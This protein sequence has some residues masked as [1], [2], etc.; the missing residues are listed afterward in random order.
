MASVQNLFAPSDLT[1]EPAEQK[2]NHSVPPAPPLILTKGKSAEVPKKVRSDATKLAI[3]TMSKIEEKMSNSVD[4]RIEKRKQV[5]QDFATARQEFFLSKEYSQVEGKPIVDAIDAY[6]GTAS[7]HRNGLDALEKV[8]AIIHECDHVDIDSYDMQ[9]TLRHVKKCAKAEL[10]MLQKLHKAI[11]ALATNNSRFEETGIWNS[12]GGIRIK[13]VRLMPKQKGT[14]FD[15]DCKSTK[16]MEDSK[17][18]ICKFLEILRS[19]V[20]ESDVFAELLIECMSEK[21]GSFD[22]FFGKGS[23]AFYD[24]F[25]NRGVDQDDLDWLPTEPV[26][27]GMLRVGVTQKE[28][29]AHVLEE[30]LLSRSYGYK[31][32]M[33]HSLCLTPGSYQNRYRQEIGIADP[34]IVFTECAHETSCGGCSDFQGIS[35]LGFVTTLPNLPVNLK[36]A[37]PLK[38]VKQVFKNLEH[39]LQVRRLSPQATVTQKFVGHDDHV[40]VQVL[41]ELISESLTAIK[42]EI[43]DPSSLVGKAQFEW[44]DYPDLLKFILMLNKDKSVAF[45]RA[46]CIK[47]DMNAYREA[48]K[49]KVVLPIKLEIKKAEAEKWQRVAVQSASEQFL[50]RQR[51]ERQKQVINTGTQGDEW[52]NCALCTLGAIFNLSTSEVS[53]LVQQ[54]LAPAGI[55]SDA[56]AQ[57]EYIFLNS[58]LGIGASGERK[59]SQLCPVYVQDLQKRTK[60]SEDLETNL[61]RAVEGDFQFEGIRLLLE[62]GV[63]MRNRQHGDVKYKVVQDGLPDLP[64]NGG[65]M[66]EWPQLIERMAAY[67]DGSQF[68]TFLSGDCNHWIYAEKI[69]GK[70]IFEDYQKNRN[71]AIN[72]TTAVGRRL[73]DDELIARY[74]DD[75]NREVE[76]H[77]DNAE[78][79]G[80]PITQQL[81]NVLL[82][83]LKAIHAR[84]SQVKQQ[85]TFQVPNSSYLISQGNKPHHPVHD[86]LDDVFNEGMYFAIVPESCMPNLMT[87]NLYEKRIHH[88]YNQLR[89][90]SKPKAT[91]ARRV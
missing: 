37:Q 81:K 89:Q 20:Y 13:S 45:D 62:K 35:L 54:T 53:T 42:K 34:S 48:V 51:D 70:I 87:L 67:P 12:K 68:Q 24:S 2:I 57:G 43:C 88:V 76:A 84:Q 60:L 41:E 28:V 9:I 74:S 4:R 83:K 32:K 64:E 82:L 10:R 14:D 5:H 7:S 61:M 27:I 47:E 23:V 80:S 65:K 78:A 40:H 63:E 29:I 50:T 26:R 31:Y 85:K 18:Q 38:V 90:L 22:M 36:A 11:E 69:N 25:D 55:R 79:A 59:L 6:E 86:D 17:R 52:T 16:R 56:S 77:R 44:D 39:T 21:Y 8:A 71:V 58:A 3:K 15:Q 30:R 46:K 66:Y 72:V 91:A 75:W 73:T 19:A 33:A 49:Q 1:R